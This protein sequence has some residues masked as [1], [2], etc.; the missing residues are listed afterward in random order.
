MKIIHG[1]KNLRIK[2]PT[3][4]TIGIFDGIHRGHKKILSLLKKRAKRIKAKSCVLTFDPHPS[5]ILHPYKKPPMLI[6][7]KHKLNLLSAEGIDI[8]VLI[9]FTKSFA[10]INPF[11]F[12]RDILAERMNVRELLVGKNFFFGKKK[13]GNVKSLRRWGKRFGFRRKNYKQ[14]TCTQVNNVGQ[15]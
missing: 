8:A 6:S 11:Y 9:N 13:S 12:A 1:I 4:A 2:E 14:H 15:A 3:V 5:K 7:T 10:D